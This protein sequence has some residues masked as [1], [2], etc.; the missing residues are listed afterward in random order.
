MALTLPGY[1][2]KHGIFWTRN[3]DSS[4]METLHREVSQRMSLQC[5]VG[6]RRVKVVSICQESCV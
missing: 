1:E 5:Y 4:E 6:N 3:V 2:Y